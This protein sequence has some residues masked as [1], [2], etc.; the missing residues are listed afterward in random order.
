MPR[1]DCCRK[2]CGLVVFKCSACDKEHCTSHQLPEA[3]NCVNMSA[4]KAESRQ[5]LTNKV[6]KDVED[7]TSSTN[8]NNFVRM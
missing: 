2:K 6:L 7:M 3:H 4:I 5:Q 8:K 1:C